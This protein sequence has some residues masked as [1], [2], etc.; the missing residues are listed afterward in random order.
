MQRAPLPRPSVAPF[1][2]DNLLSRC[3]Y[4]GAV[5]KR[6]VPTPASLWRQ[7]KEIPDRTQLIDA[8]LFNVVGHPWMT[9]VKMAQC[10]FLAQPS[11]DFLHHRSEVASQFSRSSG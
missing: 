5:V 4:F 1:G 11:Y 6:R 9:T 3:L 10:S 7:I 2:R 8:A